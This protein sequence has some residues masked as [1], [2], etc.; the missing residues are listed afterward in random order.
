MSLSLNRYILTVSGCELIW[1]CRPGVP[2]QCRAVSAILPVRTQ[3][4]DFNARQA[5]TLW[6]QRRRRGPRY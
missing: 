4:R 5:G 1:K 3:N 2:V 6:S